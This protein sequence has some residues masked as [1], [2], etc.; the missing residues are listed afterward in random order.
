VV[1]LSVPRGFPFLA[2]ALADPAASGRLSE[3]IAQFAGAPLSVRTAER[4]PEPEPDTDEAAPSASDLQRQRL[5]AADVDAIRQAPITKL[6]E[7]ELAGRIVHM[8]R[9]AG[10]A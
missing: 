4:D 5:S 6:I 3:I 10:D 1:V 7:S 8:E 2:T 9:H